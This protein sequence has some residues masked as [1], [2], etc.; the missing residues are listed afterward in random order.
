MFSLTLP[1][2]VEV[3]YNIVDVLGRIVKDVRGHFKAGRSEIPIE[4]SELAAGSY[5]LRLSIPGEAIQTLKR[6]KS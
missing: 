4:L 3:R 2:S 1:A 6:I 5:F